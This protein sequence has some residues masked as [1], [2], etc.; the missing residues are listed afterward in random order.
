MH[1]TATLKLK[2]LKEREALLKSEIN[3]LNTNLKH[4]TATLITDLLDHYD[5]LTLP[6]NSLLGV[7]DETLASLTITPSLHPKYDAHGQK[8]R[9]K[10]KKSRSHSRG[11]RSLKEGF[12]GDSTDLKGGE[13]TAL[14]DRIM[15]LKSEVIEESQ[16]RKGGKTSHV[17]HRTSASERGGIP[18]CSTGVSKSSKVNTPS[19]KNA[20]L[21]GKNLGEQAPHSHA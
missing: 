5:L 2:K 15:D 11:K 19:L 18:P 6:Q 4:E 21:T 1:L 17:N 16:G 10:L 20:T 12:K 7:L 14:T 13:D 8:V 9:Q 3:T